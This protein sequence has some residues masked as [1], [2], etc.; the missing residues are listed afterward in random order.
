[1]PRARFN[2]T[3]AVPDEKVIPRRGVPHETVVE[4]LRSLPFDAETDARGPVAAVQT[5][6][7]LRNPS[8]DITVRA[9]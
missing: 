8:L 7:A 3:L 6:R 2:M 5:I 4:M 1:M 9:A